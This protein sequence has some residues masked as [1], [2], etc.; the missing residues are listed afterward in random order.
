MPKLITFSTG[1]SIEFL[2]DAIGTKLRKTTK[3]GATVQYVQDY[4][5][6][7]IEYRQTGTGV[8]RVESVYHAEGRYYNTNVDAADAI[9]W[10]KEYN[11]RDYLGNTRLAFTDRN[12]NGIVDITGTASTS[13][14]LQ[15]NHYYSFGLAFEGPWLQ[16]DAGVRDNA[17]MYN[18]KELHSDFGLGMYAYGA[19]YY[20]PV[21]GRFTGVDPIAD[22]FP[23][24]TTFNYAENEP[25]A[26]IDLHGLQKVGVNSLAQ[27]VGIPSSDRGIIKPAS[28]NMRASSPIKAGI[29]DGSFIV[30][31]LMGVNTLDN[32]IATWFDP[33]ATLGE[34]VAAVGDLAQGM[35]SN[36]KR[37]SNK[38]AVEKYEIG[39][40][41]DLQ[42]RSASGDGLDLHHVP[43][44]K[45]AGQVVDG[46]D[47]K[48]GPAIALPQKVHKTIPTKKG[49]YE[50]TARDQLAKDSKDLRKAGVPNDKVQGIIDYNKKKYPDSYEKEVN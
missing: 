22:E 29:K 23:F 30:L 8:K 11:F 44:K 6:N 3:V 1:N 32:A 18:S 27:V 35:L 12:A 48:D 4:L 26:N 24:V 10:R 45:P 31:D 19:R 9:V 33:N 39:D 28:A 20:D 2:Y 42:R 43:Q 16:N 7:G 15:E 50:G 14:V 37:G 46:Y 41:D 21:I 13:D 40:Y 47:K 49:G 38:K 5:P 36:T 17:Y 25:I 34:K